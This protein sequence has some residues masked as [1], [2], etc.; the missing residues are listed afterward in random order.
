[1]NKYNEK[2]QSENDSYRESCEPVQ[3]RATVS[4]SHSVAI[5]QQKRIRNRMRY[6]SWG[7]L[8]VVC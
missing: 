6:V 3:R 4:N 2:T 8:D 7:L 1:M 5:A